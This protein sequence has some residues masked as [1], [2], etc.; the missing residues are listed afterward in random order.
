MQQKVKIIHFALCLGLIIAY[1]LLGNINTVTNFSFES[2]NTSNI[3]Y[4]LIPVMAYLLSNS[5]FNSQLKNIDSKLKLEE[6]ITFYQSASIMRWAVLEGA[7]FLILFLNKDFMIFGV[8]I[9]TYLIFIRPTED[10]IRMKLA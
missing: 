5:L 8:L 6:K 10:G 2:I 9:I 7:A 3:I 4:P 1:L